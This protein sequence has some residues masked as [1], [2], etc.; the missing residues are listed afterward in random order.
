MARR[1]RAYLS[2]HPFGEMGEHEAVARIAEVENEAFG[3]VCIKVDRYPRASVGVVPGKD[4]VR[5]FRAKLEDSVGVAL[6]R[7]QVASSVRCFGVGAGGEL[8]GELPAADPVDY[9]AP[10][11]VE[12]FA[13]ARMREELPV[14]RFEVCAHAPILPISPRRGPPVTS[15]TMPCFSSLSIV[16]SISRYVHETASLP[17]DRSHTLRWNGKI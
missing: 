3:K 13:R 16:D 6:E 15:T 5:V 11:L 7:E 12:R 1:L 4:G 10:F 2:L 8:A 9:P 17:R 14:N